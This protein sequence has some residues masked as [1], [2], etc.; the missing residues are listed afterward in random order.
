MDLLQEIHREVRFKHTGI[1]QEPYSAPVH[2]NHTNHLQQN[3]SDLQ[4]D[5]QSLKNAIKTPHTQYAAPLD[6][7]PVALQQ[8]LSKM[9]EEIKDLQ[10]MKRP[11]VY[12]TPP[13]H[14]RSFRTTDGLVICPQ[15]NQ[16]G[17]FARACTANL[18]PPRAP[19]RYQN[20]RYT[21]S[22]LPPPNTHDHRTLPIAPPINT[23]NTLP[24]DHRPIDT[25]LWAILTREMPPTPI[26]HNK[27]HSHPPLK[28]TASTKLEDL[29]FQV[30]T[31]IIVTPFK[32][33][34]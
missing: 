12:P 28:P 9:K 32:N 26:L 25:I 2:N 13:E 7:N 14:Y 1:K 21:M 23:P 27:H 18:P 11:N 3:N 10:Q 22:P 20:H 16:V 8:L 33:M 5:M 15:C 19:T 6:T 34:L 24:T 30:K 31:T 4:T 17:H 29:I